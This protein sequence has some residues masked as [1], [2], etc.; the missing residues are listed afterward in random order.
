M[1]LFFYLITPALVSLDLRESFLHGETEEERIDA[2]KVYIYRS[3][4]TL[5][6]LRVVVEEGEPEGRLK[7]KAAQYKEAFPTIPYIEVDVPECL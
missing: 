7:A 6:Q 1:L 2:M 5:Q 4:C 3:G